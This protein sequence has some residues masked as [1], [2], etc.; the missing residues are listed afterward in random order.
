MFREIDKTEEIEI[1]EDTE[2]GGR[3]RSVVVPSPS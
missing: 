2:A 3:S 1:E